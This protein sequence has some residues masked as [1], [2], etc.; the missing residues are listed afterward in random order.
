MHVA[1]GDLVIHPSPQTL[2]VARFICK[3]EILA[4]TLWDEGQ[5]L[6]IFVPRILKPDFSM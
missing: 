1:L 2:S 3:T 4:L 5:K 6:N